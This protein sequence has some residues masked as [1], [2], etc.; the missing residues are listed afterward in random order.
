MSK[1][2]QCDRCKGFFAPKDMDTEEV[3]MTFARIYDQNFGCYECEQP[4]NFI[5]DEH[6]CPECTKKFYDFMENKAID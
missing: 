2:F 6:L 3:F 5:T 1:A 4:H